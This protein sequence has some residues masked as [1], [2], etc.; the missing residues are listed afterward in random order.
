MFT[1]NTERVQAQKNLPI[2][3]IIGNPP[4]NNERKE[5]YPGLKKRIEETYVADSSATNSN[6]LYNSYYY[7][8][9]W[10]SDRIGDAGVVCF[11][12]GAGWLRGGAGAGV[13]ET[14]VKEFN[15]IYVYDL[16]G[17]KQFTNLTKEQL[18]DEGDNIF[19]SGSKS[20]I[21]ITLLVKNPNSAHRGVIHYADCGIGKTLEEKKAQ[22]QVVA[23]ADPE[24]QPLIPD[25]H[26]DWLDHRDET[27]YD[28]APIAI[29]EGVK[30]KPTGLFSTWSSG[31]KTQRDAWAYN[32]SEEQVDASMRKTIDF[33][34]VQLDNGT[35]ADQL[36][37]D[38]AITWTAAFKSYLARGIRLK[39]ETGHIVRSSYRPFCKQYLWFDRTTNERVYLQPSMFPEPDSKNIEI[40]IVGKNTTHWSPFITNAVPDLHL[41][42]QS[43]CFPLYWYEEVEPEEASV[44]YR[45][46]FGADQGALT[47]DDSDSDATGGGR[48]FVRHDAITDTARRVFRSAYPGVRITKEDIFYYV[49]GVLHSP[50]Y[51]RRFENNLKKELPRIPLA[52]D[53]KAFMK[54][55]RA[56][57]DLHLNYESV[58]RWPLMEQGDTEHPGRTEKMTYPVKVKDPETGRMIPDK[59]ILKVAENLTI[60][61]IP[62]RAYGYVVNGKSA[63]GWLI[64]R[65]KVTVDKKSGIVN[66]PNEY[67]DDPRYIVDLVERVITV[68]MRTLD[69]VDGLPPLDELPQPADWPSEWK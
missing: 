15:D 39:P 2:R 45:T 66:D 8:M 68:S 28:F 1:E 42:W 29:Q 67:S 3:V 34:N 30:K 36:P 9:R 59:T 51:R 60:H 65:Y 57:A 44:G 14:F 22:L 17:N 31:V 37:E 25:K 41:M 61:G 4:Y 21:A 54:A 64:D 13:R 53:F 33:Y 69:I 46:L 48:R 16:R 20:P 52:K 7:A 56:L 58:D 62:L 49:Y 6:S 40:C 24:W 12:S 43:Q 11:V 55:G 50:E 47:F 32:F 35:P 18:A 63:I 19:S 23:E 38:P 27:Y 5:L 10:A 26:G